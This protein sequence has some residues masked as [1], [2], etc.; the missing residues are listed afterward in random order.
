MDELS[1]KIRNIPDFPK[2]GIAF[3]DITPLLQDASSFKRAILLLAKHYRNSKISS[4][5]SVE[6]RGFI[7]G[8]ALAYELG[9]GFIPVR[10]PGK[11]PYRVKRISYSLEYGEDTI[12]IH[13]DAIE[14]GEKVLVVD[15]LIATGGTVQAV[16]KLVEKLGGVVVGICFLVELTYLKG[17]EKLKDYD[18]FSLIKY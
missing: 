6:S 1:Q 18:I 8:A 10:K 2:K 3:K 15:D 12:E 16:C 14:K 4:L 5:V 9:V 13:E 11:L 17:R 7:L